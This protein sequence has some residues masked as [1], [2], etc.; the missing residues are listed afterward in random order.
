MLLPWREEGFYLP[1]LEGMALGTV[2]VCPTVFG[3]RSFCLPEVNCF[4]PPYE[5][6]A[7]VA[8]AEA[9]LG[10]LPNL[11]R[12][13]S[14]GLQTAREHDLSRERQAFLEILGQVNDLWSE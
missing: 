13:L 2:V 10:D 3:N 5:E 11:D 1:A 8:A 9:A 6:D 7:L 12:M 14:N 4:R